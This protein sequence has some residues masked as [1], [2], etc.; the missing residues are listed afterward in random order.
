MN[1][2]MSFST[3]GVGVVL[4]AS[5]N[6][7]DIFLLAAFFADGHLQVRNIVTG[8]FVGIGA[9][10]AASAA[11]AA[12]ALVIPEGWT[13]LLGI[14]PLL[15]GLLKLWQ[16]ISA[17]HAHDD[18]SDRIVETERAAERRSHSQVLAVAAVTMANGGDNLGVYIPVFA[19]NVGAIPAYTALFVV[20]TGVW[21]TAGYVLVHNPLA[22][23]RIR[24]Y[25]HVMLPI[26]LIALGVWILTG[27]T[28][29]L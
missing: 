6:I 13:S 21:C 28:V 11:A 15:I 12:A 7:D 20:L 19:T 1:L 22:G 27:A 8:Q 9:L 25:G 18:E 29:L 17:K 10:T 23:E 26:V 16:L 3:L 14:A 4:F 5:T 24:R 2:D